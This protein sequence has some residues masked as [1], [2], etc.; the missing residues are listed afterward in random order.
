MAIRAGLW[1]I[2]VGAA[3]LGGVVSA[4]GV[5][6]PL[7]PGSDVSQDAPEQALNILQADPDHTGTVAREGIAGAVSASAGLPAQT[8]SPAT[9]I[10]TDNPLTLAVT[11]LSSEVLRKALETLNPG[12]VR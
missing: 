10:W 6:Y 11:P 9:E 5:T 8:L 4:K 7:A 12:P 3:V 1:A 2:A